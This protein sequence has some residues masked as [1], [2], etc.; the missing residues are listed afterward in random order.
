ML[1]GRGRKNIL[2]MAL[3]NL[4]C[5]QGTSERHVGAYNAGRGSNSWQRDQPLQTVNKEPA[6]TKNGYNKTKPYDEGRGS[7]HWNSEPAHDKRRR[8]ERMLT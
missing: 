4:R 5:V 2:G 1:S 6:A 8:D 7:R 3:P